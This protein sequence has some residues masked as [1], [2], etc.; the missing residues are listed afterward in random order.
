MKPEKLKLCEF[1]SPYYLTEAA[2]DMST[3]DKQVAGYKD[4]FYKTLA[5]LATLSFQLQSYNQ[6]DKDQ[7]QEKNATPLFTSLGQLRDKFTQLGLTDMDSLA[8]MNL[9]MAQKALQ[10]GATFSPVYSLDTAQDKTLGSQYANSSVG[11]APSQT[12]Q[13]PTKGPAF[14]GTSGWQDTKRNVPYEA[15]LIGNRIALDRSSYT[16]RGRV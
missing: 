8:Q 16:N 11:I 6:K 15:P 14:K 5:S 4:S 1:V 2:L 9:A 10:S 7:F 13:A 12:V 3:P